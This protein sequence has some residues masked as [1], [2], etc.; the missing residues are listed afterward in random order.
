MSNVNVVRIFEC[1]RVCCWKYYSEIEPVTKTMYFP[2]L[3]QNDS[4]CSE[5]LNKP[6]LGGKIISRAELKKG[7]APFF[8]SAMATPSA[9]CIHV[10]Y[11]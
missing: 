7:R 2:C 11:Q 6:I 5:I 4:F 3:H 9:V 8:N 10:T 1:N